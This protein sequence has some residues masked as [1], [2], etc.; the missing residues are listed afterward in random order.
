MQDC[1]NAL[2]NSDVDQF[3]TSLLDFGG[4]LL[5]VSCLQ[6]G[7]LVDIDEM[8]DKRIVETLVVDIAS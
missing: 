3:S 8:A 4:S 7:Y 2:P 5:C 6:V 1:Y